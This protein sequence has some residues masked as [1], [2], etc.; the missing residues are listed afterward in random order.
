MRPS[1]KLSAL[2]ALLIALLLAGGCTPTCDQTC[3]KLMRCEGLATDGL[4]ANRCEESCAEAVALYEDWE[5]VQLQDALDE[6]KRCIDAETC[7]AIADGACYD[8]RLYAY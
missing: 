6:E 2:P 7:E 8:E 4:D 1:G 5:D 3:K